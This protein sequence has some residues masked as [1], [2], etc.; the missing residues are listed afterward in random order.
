MKMQQSVKSVVAALTA[1]ALFATPAMAVDVPGPSV[2]VSATVS[3]ALTFTVTILELIPNGTGGTTLG[4]T[5]VTSM[6][7]GTLA[8]NGTFDPDGTG[9][10]TPQ[11]RA[12][13]STKAFQ[14]FFGVNSQQRAFT[15][16]HTAGPLQSGVNT[17]PAGSFVVT[18]LTGIGGDTT[19]GDGGGPLPA[20]ITVAPKKSAIGTGVVLFSSTG[21]PSATMAATFGITDVAVP[22]TAVI[23]LDQPAG[24]Y[25]TTV[26]FTLTVV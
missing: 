1:S 15:V 6:A 24:S 9:P 4:T 19:T 16:K 26:T 12:L 5:P 14:A 23:P 8:S 10:L 3:A 13:N 21:G 25:T 11:P 17:I 20:N 22:A 2:P 18:P 7:F